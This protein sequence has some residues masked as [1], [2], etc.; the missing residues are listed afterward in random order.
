MKVVGM[1]GFTALIALSLG[2]VDAR[3]QAV[4]AQV[5]LPYSGAPLGHTAL[6]TPDGGLVV[7][8][9]PVGLHGGN[10]REMLRRD[11]DEPFVLERRGADLQPLWSV[12]VALSVE[13]ATIREAHVQQ[14]SWKQ[15]GLTEDA[16]VLFSDE[17]DALRA[18]RFDLESGAELESRVLSELEAEDEERRG[19]FA[20][21]MTPTGRP[22]TVQQAAASFASMPGYAY[23]FPTSMVTGDLR[24]AVIDGALEPMRDV[25]LDLE[26]LAPRTIG[27]D[28]DGALGIIAAAEEGGALSFIWSEAGAAAVSTPLPLK[29][30]ALLQLRVA[31][32]AG[33]HYVVALEAKEAQGRIFKREPS[34]DLAAVHVIEVDPAAG[35]VL[36]RWRLGPDELAA[37]GDFDPDTL[38][39]RLV[40][41]SVDPDGNLLLVLQGT[42][43]TITTTTST[44]GDG[45]SS[46]SRSSEYFTSDALVF[47][48]TP[49]EGRRWTAVVEA[50]GSAAVPHE[51]GLEA[52]VGDGALWMIYRGLGK[53]RSRLGPGVYAQPIQLDDGAVG[54]RLTIIPEIGPCQGFVSGLTLPLDDAEWLVTTRPCGRELS[55]ER[56]V[57]TRV[58]FGLPPQSPLAPAAVKTDRDDPERRLGVHYANTQRGYGYGNSDRLRGFG[59]G[60]AA[61]A[62]GGVAAVAL[63]PNDPGGSALYYLGGVTTGA[64]V[65]RYAWTAPDAGWWTTRSPGFQDGYSSRTGQ[66]NGRRALMWSLLGSQIG[67]IVG[68]QLVTEPAE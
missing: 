20:F 62:L 52:A 41:S 56:T 50:E 17:G 46:T 23:A 12:P 68:A 22:W 15:L 51:L 33:H 1:V 10:A 64:L 54:E 2:A 9:P 58:D 14:L 57:M 6:T 67:A 66:L 11:T 65:A 28:R 19:F 16:V 49:G 39:P 32:G 55:A 60:A 61:G 48:V 5:M 27:V 8:I 53:Y 59:V 25:A 31:S 24:V 42:W 4:S 44:S 13:T 29:A 45:A 43:L 36:G 18:R 7:L 21:S 47:S 26:G 38:W 34:A 30:D 63:A 3:A 40:R 37:G 35:T